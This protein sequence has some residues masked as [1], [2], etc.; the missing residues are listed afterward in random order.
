MK[1]PCHI[2][3]CEE[4]CLVFAV[5]QAFQDQFMVMCPVCGCDHHMK[6]VGDGE[7]VERQEGNRA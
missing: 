7:I 3:E 5:E 6:D 4:C 2:Y 1:R